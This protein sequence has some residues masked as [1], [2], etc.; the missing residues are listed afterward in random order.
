MQ[1]NDA[2]HYKNVLHYRVARNAMDLERTSA[3]YVCYEIIESRN[4][5]DEI[6]EHHLHF[7]IATF[8]SFFYCE[9]VYVDLEPE[10]INFLYREGSG[11]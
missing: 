10:F 9:K 5:H 7:H 3:N 6:S 4:P 11:C 8:A 1:R 2:L